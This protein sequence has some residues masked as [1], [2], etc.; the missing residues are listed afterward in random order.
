[1]RDVT[2]SLQTFCKRLRSRHTGITRRLST[3]F[4][5]LLIAKKRESFIQLYIEVERQGCKTVARQ[6]GN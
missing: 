5:G 4:R 6:S 2:F 3:P 1:M